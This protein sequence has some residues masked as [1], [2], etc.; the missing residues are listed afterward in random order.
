MKKLLTI[1]VLLLL[2]PS[3]VEAVTRQKDFISIANGDGDIFKTTQSSSAWDDTH[4]ASTGTTADPLGLNVDVSAQYAAGASLPRDAATIYR[5]WVPVDLSNEPIGARVETAVFR[6]LIVSK[7]NSDNDG[8]DFI[9]F[10]LGNQSSTSTLITA[11]YDQAGAI[12][13]P[14]EYSDRIDIGNINTGTYNDW[15]LTNNATEEIEAQVGFGDLKL[16]I[17]EGHDVTDNSMIS[18]SPNSI[19]FSSASPFNTNKPTLRISDHSYPQVS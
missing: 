10:T 9:V 5:A 12:N 1:L 8:D 2:F 14:Q 13:N 19:V 17:R 11:D 3:T 18:G 15:S 16:S 6:L 4:D 7:Q